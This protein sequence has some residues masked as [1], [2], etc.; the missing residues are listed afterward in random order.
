MID[1]SFSAENFR[2]IYDLEKRKGA[3]LDSRFSSFNKVYWYTERIKRWNSIYRILNRQLKLNNISRTVFDLKLEKLNKYK[4]KY[5]KAREQE[6]DS[7]FSKLA[8]DVSDKSF[9]FSLLRIKKKKAK[10]VYSIP[11]DCPACFFAI[12]QIQSNLNRTYQVKQ[13][14]RTQ[15][16]SALIAVLDNNLPKH[17]FRTDIKSFY[18]SIPSNKVLDYLSNDTLLTHKNKLL[19]SS[20]FSDYR[21]LS[22]REKGLPRG[23]G[24]SAYLSEIYM[25][26]LDDEIRQDKRVIFYSRYVDDVVVVTLGDEKEAEQV[27]AKLVSKVKYLKLKLNDN[28][29]TKPIYFGKKS[30][31]KFDYLGY[32]FSKPSNELKVAISQSKLSRIKKRIDLSFDEFLY[33]AY[34]N[35]K[36][37]SNLLLARVRFLTGNTKLFGMKKNTYVGI[38]F[39]NKF[40]TDLDCLDKL[41]AHLNLRLSELS[42]KL[43]GVSINF[44]SLI[45]KFQNYSFRSGF[46]NK[47]FRVFKT[48]KGSKISNH[49]FFSKVVKIWENL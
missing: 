47:T 19:L 35:R 17:V 39:S 38:Y 33:Q 21:N 16:I 10:P 7:L 40:I 41:D 31:D 44:S 43:S 34:S 29:T 45:T 26:Q 14:D 37:A 6:L 32:S 46:E 15:I 25:R 23:V 49:M 24:V 12:K 36:K 9:S 48:Q 3:D 22:N 4:A 2:K 11:E 1:Q 13:S 5:L 30:I 8:E 42:A 28:K 27:L 18:E 20:I